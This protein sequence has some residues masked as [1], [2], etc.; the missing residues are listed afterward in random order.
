MRCEEIKEL[1]HEYAVGSLDQGQKLR[2]ESHVHEC[3]ECSLIFRDSNELW[4]ILDN[5]DRIEPGEDFVAGFWKRISEDD[6]KGNG[7]LDFLRNLRLNWALGVALAVIMIV[8]V[9]T[10]NIFQSDRANVVFTEND[11]A[12]EELLIELDKAISR[13]TAT[14]LDIYGPWEQFDKSN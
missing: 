12:D 13:E 10:L 14:S 3:K 7:I 6:V 1:F 11:E 8:S 2:V 9:M 4:N 5:W